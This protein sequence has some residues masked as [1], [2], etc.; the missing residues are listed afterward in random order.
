MMCQEICF[1]NK[2]EVE[3]KQN[4]VHNNLE[5][6]VASGKTVFHIIIFNENI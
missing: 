1:S 4:T 6:T 5:N 3:N 2:K